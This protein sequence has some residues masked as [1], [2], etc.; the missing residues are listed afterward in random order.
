MEAQIVSRPAFTVVGV[1][2][3]GKNEHNEMRLWESA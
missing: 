3:R 2:Y 1:L